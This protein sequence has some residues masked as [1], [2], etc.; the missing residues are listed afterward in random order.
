MTTVAIDTLKTSQKLQDAG[1]S[2]KQASGVAEVLA[3]ALADYPRKDAV[4]SA[5]E[6]ATLGINR[7][8]DATERRLGERLDDLKAEHGAKLSTLEAGQAVLMENQSELRREVKGNG[9]MLA[10]ILTHLGIPVPSK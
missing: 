4:I 8:I 5:V 6:E 3:D 1:F 2:K 10:A 9:A 7:R